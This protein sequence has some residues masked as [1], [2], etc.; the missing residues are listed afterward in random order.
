VVFIRDS[1]NAAIGIGAAIGEAIE[2]I[3]AAIEAIETGVYNFKT[4]KATLVIDI[5][6]IIKNIMQINAM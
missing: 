2:A 3:G 5:N 4:S 1:A 6:S